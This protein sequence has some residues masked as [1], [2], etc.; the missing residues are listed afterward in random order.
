MRYAETGFNLEV[1]LSEGKTRKEESDPKL[2]EL[3]LGGQGTADKILW[4]RVPGDVDPFSPDNLLIFSTGL[5]DATPVPGANRTI[6]NTFSPM[7]NLHAHSI[8]GGFFGPE[9]KYAGYDKIILRPIWFI[10]GSITTRWK[11]GTPL[12]SEGKG[13]M[14]QQN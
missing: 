10:Y 12:I 4:D 6:V 9:M 7:T 5:L 2:T 11:F 8:M 3:H 1:D 14:R 13:V